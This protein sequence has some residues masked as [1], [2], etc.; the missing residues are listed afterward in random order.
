M[1]ISSST[2]LGDLTVNS[3]EADGTDDD[4]S[5]AAPREVSLSE[6]WSGNDASVEL[7]DDS[8]GQAGEKIADDSAWDVRILSLLSKATAPLPPSMSSRPAPTPSSSPSPAI[9]LRQTA[10]NS[11]A[12]QS[13]QGEFSTVDEADLISVTGVTPETSDGANAL[14]VGGSRS[15]VSDAE[16]NAHYGDLENGED[17]FKEED[18][19]SQAEAAE[20]ELLSSGTDNEG[21]SRGD[22]DGDGG[23][24]EALKA[25][26]PFTP[27]STSPESVNADIVRVQDCHE[28]LAIAVVGNIQ[29]KPSSIAIGPSGIIA[30][31]T[32]NGVIIV[33]RPDTALSS[34]AMKH[35]DKEKHNDYLASGT[36]RKTTTLGISVP[37]ATVTSMAFCAA[38]KHAGLHPASSWLLAGHRDGSIVL[39]DVTRGTVVKEMRGVHQSPVIAVALVSPTIAGAAAAAA[40]AYMSVQSERNA[41][42]GAGNTGRFGNVGFSNNGPVEAISASLSGTVSR[43][44]LTSIG[45]L[46]RA[47]A[48]CMGERTTV[49]QI[50]PLA[51]LYASPR[52][53]SS[54]ETK[55]EA[56]IGDVD[57]LGVISLLTPAAI[58]LM[59]LQPEARVL[60][61]LSRPP[62][63]SYNFIPCFAWAPR[64]VGDDHRWT[65]MAVSWGYHIQIAHLDLTTAINLSSNEKSGVNCSRHIAIRREIRVDAPVIAL[66]WLTSGIIVSVLKSNCL[67]VV[68]SRTGEVIQ[69]LSACETPVNFVLEGSSSTYESSGSQVS[70]LN[71]DVDSDEES[72]RRSCH[73]SIATQ[74]DVLMI[75]SR[76]RGCPI[77][78]ASVMSWRER[79]S[80]RVLEKDWGGAFATALTASNETDPVQEHSSDARPPPDA[81]AAA[82]DLIPQF[83]ADVLNKNPMETLTSCKNADT[84]TV[85]ETS[86]IRAIHIARAVVAVCLA[87]GGFDRLY[88]SDVY[89]A[90]I[91]SPYTKSAFL[92]LLVPHIINDRLSALP[93]EVMQSL[94]EHFV[95]QGRPA[96]IERCVLHM[97]IASLDLNQCARLCKKH[98]LFS[99]LAHVFN[100]ALDDFI[101]PAAALLDA[102]TADAVAVLNR[103]DAMSNMI[104]ETEGGG[105]QR[106]VSGLECKV[107]DYYDCHRRGPAYKLLLYLRETLRGQM[108]PPGRGALQHNR[109]PGVRAELLGFLLDPAVVVTLSPSNIVQGAVKSDEDH[110][111]HSNCNTSIKLHSSDLGDRHVCFRRQWCGCYINGAA[112]LAGVL[113]DAASLPSIGDSTNLPH[114]HRL[115]QRLTFLIGVETSVTLDIL[116]EVFQ[117]WDA[118]ESECFAA[119]GVD[120]DAPADG[121]GEDRMVS[122]VV[123]DCAIAVAEAFDRISPRARDSIWRCRKC[124]PDCEGQVVKAAALARTRLLQFVAEVVAS[125]RATLAGI[126]RLQEILLLE[127]LALGQPLSSS[128]TERSKRESAMVAILTRWIPTLKVHVDKNMEV[129]DGPEELT[130]DPDLT[131][132]S[133]LLLVACQLSQRARFHQA[134]AMCHL[135]NGN[136]M[137][138]LHAL[139]ADADRPLGLLRYIDALLGS[140]FCEIYDLVS[141][142]STADVAVHVCALDSDHAVAF[143]NSLLDD[144]PLLATIAPD[145]TILLAMTVFSNSQDAVLATLSKEPL[146]EYQYL[147]R[148]FAG[149]FAAANND[150]NT[151]VSGHLQTKTK[152]E[153]AAHEVADNERASAA[154]FDFF[155]IS[156][157][158]ARLDFVVTDVLTERYIRLMCQFAPRDVKNFLQESVCGYNLERCLKCCREYHV[159]D[160]EA[161]ILERMDLVDEALLLR[162]DAY[163][164]H[165]KDALRQAVVGNSD[166][167]NNIWMNSAPTLHP[168]KNPSSSNRHLVDLRD[169]AVSV[170]GLCIRT[171]S[172]RE[173][174]RESNLDLATTWISFLEVIVKQLRK[175]RGK[176]W[177]RVHISLADSNHAMSLTHSIEDA[178]IC[179]T[180]GNDSNGMC[181]GVSGSFN[182]LLRLVLE[183]NACAVAD[184]MVKFGVKTPVTLDLLLTKYGADDLGNFRFIVTDLL[185]SFAKEVEM[186]ESARQV[187]KS[188]LHTAFSRKMLATNRGWSSRKGIEIVNPSRDR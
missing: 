73:T 184:A 156:K 165:L 10:A 141:A 127:A 92:E 168:A 4:T 155:S 71:A 82:Q 103:M 186:L 174:K 88:S 79:M 167:R 38:G 158:V 5:S 31:G 173:W 41:D 7:D 77:R 64:V 100:R 75:L 30:V 67:V 13:R 149:A 126:S 58:V 136:H 140:C 170:L 124:G 115:P 108:F 119:A 121:A 117:E 70:N 162:I 175:L 29:G 157:L 12:S 28:D 146:L 60:A 178:P 18:P 33:S 65:H 63:S 6:S 52:Y 78:Q 179:T 90:L 48:S 105:E 66:G 187:A 125:G 180:T 74:G 16:G 148:V 188:D 54:E 163:S 129:G 89:G 85:A 120:A 166:N 109:I 145:A 34:S 161:Y 80:V 45:P 110:G 93:P 176:S 112:G 15:W 102:A 138:A 111:D 72:R 151:Q 118:T 104:A 95:Q 185:A 153:F 46:V 114:R 57:A 99:A 24:A 59:R 106:D 131:V 160:A 159:L 40:L 164:S 76:S 143:L 135:I 1:R 139:A 36:K 87:T 130:L 21:V 50:Q 17:I 3:F 25:L 9:P 8:L 142:Q 169:I 68:S 83:L 2:P 171:Y 44:T 51:T 27:Q 150:K 49:L 86:R 69:T 97:D 37:G 91:A 55:Q 56:S 35:Q 47:R 19:L 23:I 133:D 96:A 123:V 43:H 183:A 81:A 62:G 134:E 122:Q 107:Q 42:S 14:F 26:T 181:V 22:G 84:A 53:W 128:T 94:V 101:V 137:S 154:G 20:R 152:L 144:L 113:W 11:I 177:R 182:V 98:G 32:T 116:S 132:N 172:K 39:W 61:K 147:S